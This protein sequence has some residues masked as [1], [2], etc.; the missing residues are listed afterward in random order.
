MK[1]KKMC[2]LV[3][4][5]LLMLFLCSCD[6]VQ[7]RE[8]NVDEGRWEVWKIGIIKEFVEVRGKD[9]AHEKEEGWCTSDWQIIFEDKSGYIL[10]N[11]KNVG[12]IKEGQKGILYKN[13][14]GHKNRISWFK[15]VVKEDALLKEDILSKKDIFFEED[16][17]FKIL[18]KI[19]ENKEEIKFIK[20]EWKRAALSKPEMYKIVLLKLE[21]EN[22]ATGYFT[23][24]KE[25]K[26][27]FYKNRINGGISLNNVV[28]WKEI[29]LN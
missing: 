8:W 19:N 12:L 1:S 17:S 16:I 20:Y 24:K 22:T 18:K 14:F 26:V 29:D 6:D 21:N 9:C 28:G 15:W 25:W 10:G 23:N 2:K 4:V 7:P 11:I 3:V 27:D 13:N 5:L